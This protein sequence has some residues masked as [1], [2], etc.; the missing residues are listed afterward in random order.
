MLAS[1]AIP[2]GWVTH[3]W[4]EESAAEVRFGVGQRPA[5]RLAALSEFV[6]ALEE[7]GF[8]CFWTSDHPVLSPRAAGR[9]SPRSPPRTRTIRLG[10]LVACI[11]YLNPVVLARTALDIDAISAGRLVVGL[12]IGD[13]AHEFARW[14][15]PWRSTRSARSA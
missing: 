5:R 13:F 3:P 14:V 10:S 6:A 2:P 11:D 12:G 1:A 15:I 9:P 8:D 7:L 4:V